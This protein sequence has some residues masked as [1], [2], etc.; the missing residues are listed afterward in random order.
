[1]PALEPGHQLLLPPPPPPPP[2]KPPPPNELPPP[3]PVPLLEA[4]GMGVAA[5]VWLVVRKPVLIA[6]LL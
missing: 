1:L 6:A 3:N 2:E 5:V 4:A